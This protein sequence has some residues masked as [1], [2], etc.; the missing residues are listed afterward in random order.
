[1]RGGAGYVSRPL[2][3]VCTLQRG[4]D[5]P[6]EQR[7][8]G[9][10]PLVTSSGPTD[11]HC[12]ARVRG[13]GVV[14]GRS[15]SIG[16]VYFIAEDFWPL[17]TALY[18]KDFHGNDER[19]VFY[20]LQAFDLSRFS[21]GAGVPTLNR[22]HVHDELVLVTS[23]RAEQKRIVEKLD[24]AFAAL[25]CARANAEANHRDTSELEVRWALEFLSGLNGASHPL[26]S[27]CDI[28]QP[29]TI[30]TQELIPD[31]QYVVFG[32]NGK[33]GRFSDYN[34]A[35]SEVLVTCRG[36]TCGQVNVSEPFSWVTGNAMVVRPRTGEL[37]KDFL[38]EVLRSLVDWSKVITGA[39]QPQIT[40]ASLAPVNVLVPEVR[41][42][43]EA[44]TKIKALRLHASKLRD[45]TQAKLAGIAALRQS[46]L[47]AAFSGQLT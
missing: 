35:D 7:V 38:E 14:T 42:Q 22:N 45:A 21:S 32:A 33:I 31:G 1:M 37:R 23:D 12:E 46:L 15:G 8:A 26:G 9:K 39:A 4:F 20:L 24:Q 2:G 44:V 11:T 3:E 19:Y 43:V 30:S 25:D 13:P 29:K 16:S 5:L 10:F 28:Y 40:R 41:V 36:A 27:I 18:V 17:N 34:H 47:Q 6:T